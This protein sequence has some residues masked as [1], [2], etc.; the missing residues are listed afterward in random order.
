VSTGQRLAPPL[1][2]HRDGGLPGQLDRV[3]DPG[4]RGRER[5]RLV[6]HLAAGVGQREEVAG[7]IPTVD[8]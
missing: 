4:E 5:E 2:T 7:E 3:A 1:V 8:R 6:D